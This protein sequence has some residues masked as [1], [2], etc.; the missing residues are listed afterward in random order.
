[1]ADKTLSYSPSGNSPG[2]PSFYSFIPDYMKGM[3]GYFYSFKNGNLFRHNTNTT[4]NNYYGIQYIS[5]I[6][7]VFNPQPTLAIKLFKTMSY[8]SNSEWTVTNLNTD[9]SSGSMLS[10]Y[11]EQKE[12]EWFSYIRS[13][14][15]T[16]DWKLRSAQGVGITTEVLGSL[17]ERVIKFAEPIGSIVNVGDVLYVSTNNNG[18]YSSPKIAAPILS[19]TSNTLT[20]DVSI[21]T[22]PQNPLPTNPT[23]DSAIL[24]YKNS[25]A[26]SNGARG[27]FMEFTMTNGSTSAV[28]LFSVGSSVMKSYP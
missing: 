19:R 27:Y 16:V 8:E 24:V 15:S 17:S 21:D 10:T 4:R 6:K 7:S 12:G 20:V 5:S 28:E 18:I 1:M 13:D 9:L 2:W 25:V 26:E 11:F 22:P 23:T 14:A 3:N